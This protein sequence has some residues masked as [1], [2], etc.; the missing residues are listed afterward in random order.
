MTRWTIA[1]ALAWALSVAGC[2]GADYKAM[3]PGA[4]AVYESRTEMDRGEDKRMRGGVGLMDPSP[5]PDK[6]RLAGDTGGEAAP[7]FKRMIVYT[8]RYTV[9][10]YDLRHAQQALV[11]FVT[12]HGGYMQQTTGNTLVL[13]IPAEHFAAIEPALRLLGRIDERLTDVR[14]RD[15]TE[16]Y[17]DLELRLKT[18][19]QYLESLRALLDEAKKLEEK[20][21]VQREIASVVEEIESMEGR[22]RL[23]QS[24]V[25]LATVT[26]NF[27]LAH[28]GPRRTFRLPFQWLDE[29]GIETL[30]R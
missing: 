6:T 15:I 7:A 3:G 8:G 1:L 28:S 2:G 13:R 30:L 22:R 16:E 21:A 10:V 19:R 9:D 14:A 4:G 27:R 12:E 29:L 17:H 23:L 18:K 25:A 11:D 26:V 5:T 20:L 24:Q